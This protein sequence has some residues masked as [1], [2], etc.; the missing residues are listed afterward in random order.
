MGKLLFMADGFWCLKYKFTSELYALYAGTQHLYS[1]VNTLGLLC[2]QKHKIEK[3]IKH[4]NITNDHMIAHVKKLK[5][6]KGPFN[7][8]DKAFPKWTHLFL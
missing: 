4:W 8:K 7:I 6:S 3:Q 1:G 2:L 5:M